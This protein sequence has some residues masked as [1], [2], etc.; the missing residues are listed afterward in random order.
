[1]ITVFITVMA[2]FFG[3]FCYYKSLDWVYDN[4]R[5]ILPGFYD[6][7]KLLPIAVIVSAIVAVG[8]SI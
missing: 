1:M 2:I 6:F 3:L 7:L 4:T 5:W 8:V